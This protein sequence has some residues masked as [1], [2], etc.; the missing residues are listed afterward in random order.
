MNFGVKSALGVAEGLR[1]KYERSGKAVD[2]EL[3]GAFPRPPLLRH[4]DDEQMRIAQSCIAL[5][6]ESVA[7]A[8]TNSSSKRLLAVVAGNSA[9]SQARAVK[10]SWAK[11]KSASPFVSLSMK[12]MK[13]EG[14]GQRY[15]SYSHALNA[16]LL[17]PP[18]PPPPLPPPT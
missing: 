1:D 15:A 2:A 13:P 17:L 3:R 18:H 5:E 7:A 12:Y 4:L 9:A 8:S 14:G 16:S 10:G 11:L 6:T